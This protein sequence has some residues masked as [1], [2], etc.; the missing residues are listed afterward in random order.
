MIVIVDSSN[1]DVTASKGYC[2][3]SREQRLLK[4]FFGAPKWW[5][6]EHLNLKATR[7]YS[8]KAIVS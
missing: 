3:F 4:I 1:A 5:R 7:Y 8:F 6:S 2:W